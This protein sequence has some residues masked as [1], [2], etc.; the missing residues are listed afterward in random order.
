LSR[1]FSTVS[2]RSVP[3]PSRT[4]IANLAPSQAY[5][6]TAFCSMR[7]EMRVL[8]GTSANICFPSASTGAS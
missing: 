8:V 4:D 7:S 3:K 6:T 2:R 5:C 1:N